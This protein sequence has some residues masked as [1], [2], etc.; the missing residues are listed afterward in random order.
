VEGF[1]GAGPFGAKGGGEPPIVPV[2]AA[3]ANAVTDVTG[4]EVRELPLTAERV[5]RALKIL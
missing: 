3:V 1:P 2:A 5:A 4:A